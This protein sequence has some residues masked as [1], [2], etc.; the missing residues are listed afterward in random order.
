MTDNS[1]ARRLIH[2]LNNVFTRVL[3][4]AELI[5]AA[6]E[7]GGQLALDARAIRDA[8]LE[9][10][11]IADALRAVALCAEAGRAEGGR[12]GSAGARTP[13]APDVERRD[14]EG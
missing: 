11:E 2:D 14:D 5:E 1:D 12:T 3:T 6:G 13:G 4:T 8:A 10:R 7:A 9:G